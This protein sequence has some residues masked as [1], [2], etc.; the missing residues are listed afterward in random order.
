MKKQET[1]GKPTRKR[2][3]SEY[4]IEA[5]S[6]TGKVGV[7][8]TAKQLGLHNSQLYHWRGKMRL[9]QTRGESERQLMAENARFKRQLAEQAEELAIVKK[10]AVYFAKSLK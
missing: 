6:L 8:E 1:Q 5:L 7:A 10:A 2:Y 9:L 3:S 4:K